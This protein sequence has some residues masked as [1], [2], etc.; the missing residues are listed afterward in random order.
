MVKRFI[1]LTRLYEIKVI[2]SYVYNSPVVIM[3]FYNNIALYYDL[4]ITKVIINKPG[5]I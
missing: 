2:K 5:V 1:I 3:Q 4:T